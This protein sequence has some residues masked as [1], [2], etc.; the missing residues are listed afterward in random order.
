MEVTHGDLKGVSSHSPPTFHLTEPEAQSNILID[1]MGNPRL[2]DFGFSSITMNDRSVN[3]STPNRRGSMRWRGPELLVSSTKVK[4]KVK[5]T[6]PTKKS[7][8]Y[9][10]AMV[11]IEVKL[12]RLAQSPVSQSSKPSDIYGEATVLFKQR[13]GGDPPDLEGLATR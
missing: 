2:T 13:R 3:A 4:G 9:S 5:S 12:S 7:D 11:V 10:L 8:M 1:A 6:R